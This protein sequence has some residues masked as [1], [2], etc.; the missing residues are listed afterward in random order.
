M[1]KQFEYCLCSVNPTKSARKSDKLCIINIYRTPTGNVDVFLDSFTN[2]LNDVTKHFDKMV[3]C[4]DL[5]INFLVNSPSL[6]KLKDLLNTFNLVNMLNE[7]TRIQTNKNGQTSCTGIDYIATNIEAKQCECEIF[8]PH[9]SDHMAQLF[10]TYRNDVE[11]V[12][13]VKTFQRKINT[14]TLNNLKQNF[15]NHNWNI[16]GQTLEDSFQLL[17]NNLSTLLN[18]FCPKIVYSSDNHKHNAWFTENIRRQKKDLMS[19]YLLFRQTNCCELKKL[20]NKQK[21]EY[22]KAITTAKRKYVSTRIE[23]SQNRTKTVWSLVNS[24]IKNKPLVSDNAPDLDEFGKFFSSIVSTMMDEHFENVSKEPTLNPMVS[25]SMFCEPTTPEEVLSVIKNLK[26]KSPGL[27]GLPVQVL[28]YIGENLVIVL[29]ELI[30][31][32]FELGVFPSILKIGCVIPIYKKGDTSDAKNYRPICI[33]HAISKI[34]E[35]I[36]FT[37][38]MKFLNANNVLSE[39]Q[40]G[41]RAHYSTT[42]ASVNFINSVHGELDKKKH[43]AAVLFDLSR[44][45]DCLDVGFLCQKLFNLG[46]RGVVLDWLI[47]FISDRYFYVSLNNKK[48]DMY[49]NDLGVP[50]GSILG[51]LLFLLYINDLPLHISRGIIISYADDTTVVAAESTAEELQVSIGDIVAD[52]EN[53]CHKN[54]LILNIDKTQ[55]IYFLREN[56]LLNINFSKCV[57]LL[58]NFIDSRLSW[59][60]QMD[61]ICKKLS[62]AYY[63]ILQLRYK[64]NEKALLQVYYALAYSALTYNILIWG[65]VNLERVFIMQKKIIR[66][67]FNLKY[68]ESCRETFKK[69][70]L[71][72][73]VS[74]YIYNCALY[75]KTNY[76]KFETN[77]V[78]HDYPT[79][80]NNELR[81]QHHRTSLS[82]TSPKYAGITIYNSLPVELKNI[83]IFMFKKKLKLFLSHKCFYTLQEYFLK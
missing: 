39:T 67:I 16:T 48:S 35:R 58:G 60:N 77:A 2:L 20:Y 82:E 26:N 21:K 65:G 10:K 59:H 36:M 23:N 52:M 38:V 4:G 81:A 5:N 8:E 43:V 55:Y 3:I 7:P 1:E 54:K 18:E 79:R 70:N 71:L 69:H 22:K 27:D 40:H 17:V 61:H 45:F 19:M 50:Q 56:P 34:V 51:P 73:V 6:S 29:S 57:N 41:F 42:T 24:R 30:N 47:S 28:K 78:N 25:A 68:R 72:T 46:I 31:R 53:W 44:A 32:S 14:R 62:K 9:I 13:D 66:L 11:T 83:N 37:R 80:N 64:M 12:Q 49:S 15:E 33:L 74:I 75:V 63:A 76:S